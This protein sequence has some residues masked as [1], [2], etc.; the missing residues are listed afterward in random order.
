[1]IPQTADFPYQNLGASVNSGFFFALASFAP[2]ARY[3][4]SLIAASS[5]GL[6]HGATIAQRPSSALFILLTQFQRLL[7]QLLRRFDISEGEIIKDVMRKLD[8]TA[9]EEWHRSGD[10]RHHI[11]RRTGT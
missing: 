11:R 9:D 8:R 7:R 1:M 3:S 4:D 6:L 10:R 2:C 5:L